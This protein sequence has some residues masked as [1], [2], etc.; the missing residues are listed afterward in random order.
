MNKSAHFANHGNIG[1]A[2]RALDQGSVV[3]ASEAAASLEALTPQVPPPPAHKMADVPGQR[4]YNLD[5]KIFDAELSSLRTCVGGGTLHT[6]YERITG[7]AEAGG[8]DYLFNIAHAVPVS[9]GIHG[10][11]TLRMVAWAA[12]GGCCRP[13]AGRRG[14]GSRTG[15]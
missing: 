11:R 14:R 3:P 1:K 12:C 10:C 6:T 15:C 4:P 5:R 2:W 13:R 9:G 8:P 7:T